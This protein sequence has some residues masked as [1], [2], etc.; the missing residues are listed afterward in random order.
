MWRL[1]GLP[2][3]QV[4][5]SHPVFSSASP[6]AVILLT[7]ICTL[8]LPEHRSYVVRRYSCH[9][10]SRFTMNIKKHMLPPHPCNGEWCTT[11]LS[12]GAE[13]LRCALWIPQMCVAR[14][15][16]KQYVGYQHGIL[17]HISFVSS[18]K[19]NC[20]TSRYV[21]SKHNSVG[22]IIT[23]CLWCYSG[24]HVASGVW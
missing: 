6:H 19:S 21:T 17:S 5:L 12:N 22:Q 10:A 20:R 8:P 16:F 15:R 23:C 2:S 11:H 14:F 7:W 18:N 13:T 4:N 24:I 1:T 3:W 9:R